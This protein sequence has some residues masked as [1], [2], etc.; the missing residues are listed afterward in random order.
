MYGG[1]NVNIT[2]FLTWAQIGDEWSAPGL[3]PLYTE[4]RISR[5]PF[6]RTLLVPKCPYRLLGEEN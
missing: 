4:E 2:I 1:V 5:Y 6:Y 3:R